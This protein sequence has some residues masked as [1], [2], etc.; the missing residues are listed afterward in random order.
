MT[1][2]T[3]TGGF[4][5][6]WLIPWVSCAYTDRWDMVLSRCRLYADDENCVSHLGGMV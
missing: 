4:S 5:P 6:H 3:G 1:R 2:I